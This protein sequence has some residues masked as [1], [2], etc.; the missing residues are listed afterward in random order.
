MADENSDS[1][2]AGEMAGMIFTL[3]LLLFVVFSIGYKVGSK[4]DAHAGAPCFPN[5]TCDASLVPV[6][7]EDVCRCARPTEVKF[8]SINQPDMAH[9]P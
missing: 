9:L 7:V 3:I 4:N 5:M 2:T 8:G 6:I 1:A